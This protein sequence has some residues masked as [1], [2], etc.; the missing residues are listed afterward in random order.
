[1]MKKGF[2]ILAALLTAFAGQASAD[3][4]SADLAGAGGE[5]IASL[6]TEA[7]QVTY[8][9]LTSDVGT[10]TGAVIMQGGATVLDLQA[11]FEFGAAAGSVAA[12][13]ALITLLENNTSAYTLVVQTAGGNLS[14]TLQNAG[15]SGGGGPGP[16]PQPGV[17]RFTVD[18]ANVIEGQ[19]LT[20]QVSR[21]GG[22]S[23]AVGVTYATAGGTATSG[24]DF[25]A[26]NGTLSWAD[27][28]S[29]S[30]SFDVPI[31]NDTTEEL[32]ESFTA[33]LSA[34]TG[35]ATI[36]VNN[37]VIAVTIGANDLGPC[38][39][40]ATRLCLPIGGEQNGRFSVDL[41]YDSVRAGGVEGDA[42]VKPLDSLGITA[43]GIMTL[44]DPANPE[45]LVKVLD[46]C[47]S[48]FQSWWVFYSATTDLGFT[49]TVIDRRTGTIK[50]Y[51]NE[52]LH[53]ADP[54]QDTRAFL[55][56]AAN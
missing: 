12:A 10:P 3:Y 22:S 32:A 27:G 29:S 55:T 20:I 38:V 19:T 43:G 30:K 45:V 48:P 56:C 52:D 23:G 51:V 54:V 25:T 47:A 18:N 21:T 24:A 14:G 50:T 42:A 37:S 44:L 15:D 26:A 5:G 7:A 1:M 6:T 39:A 40:S 31:T 36:A 9:I 4:L 33:T 53:A 34:P 13:G 17:L 46:A 2:W 11:D 35:G 49:L 8:T 16:T 41:H 28:D